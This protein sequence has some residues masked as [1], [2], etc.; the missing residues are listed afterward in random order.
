M[1]TLIAL[2]DATIG[3]LLLGAAGAC[4][5]AAPLEAPQSGSGV[6]DLTVGDGGVQRVLY[7][8]HERPRAVIVFLPGGL[9]LTS[10]DAAGRIDIGC[11]GPLIC[12][13]DIWMAQGFAVAVLH[14]PSPLYGE[15]S[16]ARYARRLAA[17][18]ADLRTRTDAPIWLVGH[19]YGTVA[20]VSG[21]AALTHGEIAGIVLLGPVT[22]SGPNA[23]ETVLGA[24]GQVTVPTL[25]VSHVRDACP[26]NPPADAEAIGRA[27][28]R[29]PRKDII[30]L[31]GGASSPYDLCSGSSAHSFGGIQ[32]QMVERVAAWIATQP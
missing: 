17:I 10:I 27:L 2:R 12:I 29:A 32:R 25:I 1:G 11:P 13:R 16:S 21:A 15:R 4:Q 26:T 31:D 8:Q 14:T 18:V 3:L 20:A 24:A 22:R 28:V 19:S 7:L 30:L 6:T 9:G 5:N 23:T